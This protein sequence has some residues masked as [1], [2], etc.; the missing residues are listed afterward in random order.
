MVWQVVDTTVSI[1]TNSKKI[2]DIID[3]IDGIVVQTNIL[4][5]TLPI[6]GPVARR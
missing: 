3:V 5:M 2:A 6:S 4:G 1:S